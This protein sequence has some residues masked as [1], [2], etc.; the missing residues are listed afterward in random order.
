M[1]L[2]S[3]LALVSVTVSM[4]GCATALPTPKV[5]YVSSV[6]DDVATVSGQGLGNENPDIS[7]YAPS[8]WTPVGGEEPGAIIVLRPNTRIDDGL[9]RIVVRK[10]GL[11]FSEAAMDR[12]SEQKTEGCT[13]VST[14]DKIEDAVSMVFD[15]QRDYYF[16]STVR[17]IDEDTYE[18]T[19]KWP[20]DWK[21]AKDDY[22]I[23]AKSLKSKRLLKQ[24]KEEAE[25][26]ERQEQQAREERETHETAPDGRHIFQMGDFTY[27]SPEGWIVEA[28]DSEAKVIKAYPAGDRDGI[29]QIHVNRYGSSKTPSEIVQERRTDAQGKGCRTAY[30]GEIGNTKAYQ[31]A[32]MCGEKKTYMFI[33]RTMGRYTYE[34]MGS[35]PYGEVRTD[36]LMRQFVK[37]ITPR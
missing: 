2:V 15:C 31:I 1:K 5:V 22:K 29:R 27:L 30:T 28:D 4:I 16:F 20:Q 37:D 34:I 9:K 6:S 8:K 24:V 7:Y 23:L 13:L 25:L 32:V 36:R 12:L 26:K 17:I 10:L 21:E 33:V 14:D 35:W 18:V 19:A 3:L 11:G